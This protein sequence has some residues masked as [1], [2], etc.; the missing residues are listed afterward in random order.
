MLIVCRCSHGRHTISIAGT[1]P[2]MPVHRWAYP[3][4]S[5]R[6]RLQSPHRSPCGQSSLRTIRSGRTAWSTCR[7]HVPPPVSARSASLMITA[8]HSLRNRQAPDRAGHG[9]ADVRERDGQAGNRPVHA[10][11]RAPMPYLAAIHNITTANRDAPISSRDTCLPTA[12]PDG[13]WL[14]AS[15][16]PGEHQ[17]Q[18]RDQRDHPLIVRRTSSATRVTAPVG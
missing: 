16:F 18:V 11:E 12:E 14:S 2:T 1:S 15:G 4:P 10:R 5:R 9:T 8:S 13:V 6:T 17:G 3:S 7:H